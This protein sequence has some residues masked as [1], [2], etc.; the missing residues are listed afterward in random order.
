MDQKD[1]AAL[2]FV[3]IGGCIG[4]NLALILMFAGIIP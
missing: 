4:F 2:F 3:I 1:Q